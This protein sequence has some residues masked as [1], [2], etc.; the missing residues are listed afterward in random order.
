[1]TAADAAEISKITAHVH[2]DGGKHP[3]PQ[4]HGRRGNDVNGEYFFKRR[5]ISF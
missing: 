2:C 4:R 1:M 5:L 3:R